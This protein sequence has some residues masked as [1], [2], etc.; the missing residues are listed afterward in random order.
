MFSTLDPHSAYFPYN[1]F[2]KLKEDQDS[3][4]YGIGVTIVHTAMALS[5][6]GRRNAG[7]EI[8]LQYGDR[9][10]EVDGKNARDWSSEQVSKNVRGA[11][12]PRLPQRQ[13]APSGSTSTWPSSRAIPPAPRYRRPPRIRPDA[14]AGGDLEVDEVARAAAGAVARTRPVRRGWR[15]CRRPTGRSS[16]RRSS[17]AA[18][19]PTQPGRIALEP[20][21]AVES[22]RPGR[23]GRGPA[24]IT[25]ER[26]RCAPRRGSPRRGPAR[27]RGP[28]GRRGPCRARTVALGEDVRGQV[29]DRDA[30]VGM[31]E[32][33]PERGA[34]GAVE[35]EE[36][37]R[38]P[39][40]LTVRLAGLRALDPRA[41]RT[42]ARRRGW[43][44]CCVRGRYGA[45]SRRG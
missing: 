25:R 11:L 15:R 45:R 38:P 16:R 18:A 32:V 3:R 34:G 21:D 5:V 14:D 24:P 43:R 26:S 39:A 7:R 33:D 17:S 4:F 28:P 19:T 2:K 44:R 22:G 29:G 36:D 35:G 40:L 8:G 10:L 37:R 12:Q 20:I 42:A 27:R 6:G 9:I 31:A 23:A 13:T 41:R 30:Q 1:Q